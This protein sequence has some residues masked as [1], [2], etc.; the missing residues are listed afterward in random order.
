[1]TVYDSIH[2]PRTMNQ[3]YFG[4]APKPHSLGPQCRLAPVKPPFPPSEI[5]HVPPIKVQYFYA[6]PI[7]IDEPL[8]ASTAA[9]PPDSSRTSR[10]SLQPFSQGDNN[11]LERAWL[12]LASAQYRRNHHHA[13]RT[14]SRSPS[15]SLAKENAEKVAVIVH[16]LAAKHAEKHTREGPAREMMMQ[17]SADPLD[18]MLAQDTIVSLCCRDLLP[19]VTNA[20]RTSFCAV[21][22]RHQKL[23]DR[24]K[25]AQD[26]MAEMSTLRVDSTA[27]VVGQETPEMPALQEQAARSRFQSS[28]RTSMCETTGD[29]MPTLARPSLPDAGISGKPFV[30]VG[31]PESPIFSPPSSLPRPTTSSVSSKPHRFSVA[32]EKRTDTMDSLRTSTSSHEE[33]P[34]SDSVD[35]PVG[36][37]RLHKVSLP[38]LQMKPIYWSPVND[39]VTVLRATWFYR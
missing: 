32:E 13:R 17:T 5:D 38:S 23:L 3:Y 15:P 30:R 20:L 11:A 25:V 18:P 33:P 4:E 21:A 16:D 19:D 14:R 36:V 2:D 9:P 24:E 8:S 31:T 10:G 7:P 35:V 29:D 39:V 34:S 26:V 1:M 12:G 27:S 6:S 28:A 22:R 37:S